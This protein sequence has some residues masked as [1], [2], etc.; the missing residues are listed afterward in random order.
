MV[1][2]DQQKD[3]IEHYIR[4][5]T[6]VQTRADSEFMNPDLLQ[7][8]SINKCPIFQ[9]CD[10]S[11]SSQNDHSIEDYDYNHNSHKII[12]SLFLRIAIMIAVLIKCTIYEVYDYDRS[13]HKNALFSRIV[14]MTAV[15]IKCTIYEDCDQDHSPHKNIMFLS[16]FRIAI[17]IAVLIISTATM[18]AVFT[19]ISYI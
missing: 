4:I 19:K 15:L 13:P 8:N 3:Q 14:T 16:L 18:I 5:E 10:Q 2:S 17:M 7:N 9:N 12:A 1:K 6:P 11:Q